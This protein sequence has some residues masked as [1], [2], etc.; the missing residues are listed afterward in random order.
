MKIYGDSIGMAFQIQDDLLD[1]TGE[2]SVLGKSIGMDIKEKKI[3]LPLIYSIKHANKS[4][5]KKIL[6]LLEE[7]PQKKQINFIIDFVKLNGGIEYT[8]EKAEEYVELAKESLKS[9]QFSE[10][11]ESLLSL[12]NFIIDRDY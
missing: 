12:S 9:I 5:S 3:T 1:Y 2:T 6:K 11:K 10:A 8:Q 4:D 7:T